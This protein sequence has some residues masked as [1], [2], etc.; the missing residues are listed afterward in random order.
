MIESF[1]KL[2][3]TEKINTINQLSGEELKDQ[4]DE[5]LEILPHEHWLVRKALIEKFSGLASEDIIPILI[6]YLKPGSEISNIRNA[7]ME[8]LTRLSEKSLPYLYDLL[9]NPNPDR[10]LYAVV[11][12]GEI[13]DPSSLD[14]LKEM[15]SDPDENVAQ[16]AIEAIGKIK[17]P[18]VVP[19]LIDILNEN[20]W[21]QYPTIM[22]LGSLKD[23]AAI[24]H[25]AKLLEEDE[26][27]AMPILEAFGQIGS[28]DAIP[29]ILNVI[30]STDDHAVIW[31]A[32]KSLWK[33]YNSTK[34]DSAL[35]DLIAKEQLDQILSTKDFNQFL[36]NIIRGDDPEEIEWAVKWC[37][38][39]KIEDCVD[40]LVLLLENDFFHEQAFRSLE[41]FDKKSISSLRSYLT[42][43][44]KLLR[45]YILKLLA[46]KDF[47][48]EELIRL[49][50][51][52]ESIVRLELAVQLPR[53]G[54][55][56]IPFLFELL[57]DPDESV[58]NTS[59]LAL[60]SFP[61]QL[62][63]D[64]LIEMIRTRAF[65]R[66]SVKYFIDLA[67]YFRVK[68]VLDTLEELFDESD[69]ELKLNL[70]KAIV[71][72][73]NTKGLKY[74]TK[75]IEEAEKDTK[76][77]ILSTISGKI[78][79][80][81]LP[82]LEELLNSPDVEIRFNAYNAI[83]STNTLNALNIL[84]DRIEVEPDEELKIFVIS[85]IGFFPPETI[86]KVQDTLIRVID[87]FLQTDNY[88][89]QREILRI[90]KVID[91]P[92]TKE[93][94]N[95]LQKVMKSPHW[96]VRLEAYRVLRSHPQ[97]VSSGNLLNLLEEES[98]ILAFKELLST[99]SQLQVKGAG[100]ILL[101]S[102]NNFDEEKLELANRFL[103]QLHF[104]NLGEVDPEKLPYSTRTVLETILPDNSVNREQI[105]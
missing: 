61:V 36:M 54:E 72:L 64:Q 49:L 99:V 46:E 25:L 14:K 92:L 60:T 40:R 52:P 57:N 69:R 62:I 67:A 66:E 17:S 37:G 82:F 32:L 75:F 104:E 28:E 98:D 58:R 43:P 78:K 83:A 38:L 18:E 84:I 4:I 27:L 1:K 13:A 35:V 20:F 53:Y 7:A 6:S 45:R 71:E 9:S 26:F 44:N 89:L 23:P 94:T 100:D 5:W 70:L 76:I 68:E 51:D 42:H 96:S 33:I 2:S 56:A 102:V 19:Y 97:F 103:P 8:I 12:L 85:L 101:K 21:L 73:D 77:R 47:P 15:V 93:F 55:K 95:F 30:R 90:L 59:Y 3:I 86:R 41:C 31:E 88:D 11:V 50:T 48:L 29:Y 87:R 80:E 63:K 65:F 81:F 34:G 74:F 24:P 16:A 39:L 10:R 22:I 79:E 105:S 91:H